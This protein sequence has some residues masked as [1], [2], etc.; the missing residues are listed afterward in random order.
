V[1]NFA[2]VMFLATV[3]LVFLM[4][5]AC[6]DDDD[7]DS[8]AGDDDVDSDDDDDATGF[9]DDDGCLEGVEAF[10][11]LMWDCDLLIYDVTNG[12]NW[13][14]YDELIEDCDP[15]II[16]CYEHNDTCEQMKTCVSET[17]G[18]KVSD[19]ETWDS[20]PSIYNAYWDPETAEQDPS[21]GQWFSNLHFSV[22]DPEDGLSGGR[23]FLHVAGTSDPFLEEDIFWDDIGAPSAPDCENPASVSFIVDF[24]GK[25]PGV[26]CCDLEVSDGFGDFSNRLTDVCVTL[27]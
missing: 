8:A 1:R 26:H 9:N 20:W 5:H 23:I 4:I 22:C 15:C 21:G 7:D 24:T 27:P 3:A 10:S 17:C 12:T 14:S 16:A 25:P 2:I 6:G 11:H 18:Y 19:D 13:L